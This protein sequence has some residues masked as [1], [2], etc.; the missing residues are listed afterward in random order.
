[1]RMYISLVGRGLQTAGVKL[2][3]VSDVRRCTRRKKPS[4]TLNL[5]TNGLKVTSKPPPTAGQAGCLQGQDRS[6]GGFPSKSHHLLEQIN[7]KASFGTRAMNSFTKVAASSSYAANGPMLRIQRLG[8]NIP[9]TLD[10]FIA[11]KS[12]IKS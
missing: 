6:A 2:V 8:N 5:G 10:I 4:L 3:T 1:M 12:A 9:S 11:S 7:F